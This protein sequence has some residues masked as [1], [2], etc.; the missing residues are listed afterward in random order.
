MQ[1]LL[2]T[3][4]PFAFPDLQNEQERHHRREH[5]KSKIHHVRGESRGTRVTVFIH[6]APPSESSERPV[7]GQ[8][9]LLLAPPPLIPQSGGIQAARHTSHDDH[10]REHVK[11]RHL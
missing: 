11:Q 6:E 8:L 1:G 10:K 9:A 3:G 4:R 2:F 5:H 7:S